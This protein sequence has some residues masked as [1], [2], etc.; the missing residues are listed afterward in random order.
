M[1]N[2]E[3]FCHRVHRGHRDN[4]FLTRINTGFTRILFSPQAC[5][6]GGGSSTPI[7]WPDH[8]DPLCHSCECRNLLKKASAFR[9]N[10]TIFHFNFLFPLSPFHFIQNPYN[11]KA[12][13]SGATS[14]QRLTK[15]MRSINRE[16]CL[17]FTVCT[18]KLH[19]LHGYG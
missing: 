1:K 4:F 14:G 6:G 10:S 19:A 8:S 18:T 15:K 7:F 12:T 9:P 3:I 5:L 16:F 11:H 2:A 13:Y 17:D